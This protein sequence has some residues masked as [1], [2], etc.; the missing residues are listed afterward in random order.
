MGKTASM[1]GTALLVGGGKAQ[2]RS[3]REILAVIPVAHT[4][5]KHHSASLPLFNL[6]IIADGNITEPIGPVLAE[7]D[8]R[9]FRFHG[10]I[11]IAQ[12]LATS[13]VTTNLTEDVGIF[14]MVR[15]EI[16]RA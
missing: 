3:R 2:G 15:L 13:I 5:F 14:R 11:G 10:R 12:I 1:P 8:L 4:L 6:Q 16:G 7:P 9:V